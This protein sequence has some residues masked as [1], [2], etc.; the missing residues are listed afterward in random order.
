M[1]AML[2]FLIHLSTALLLA[3]IVACGVGAVMLFQ[4]GRRL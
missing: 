1:R 2:P 4:W 3:A